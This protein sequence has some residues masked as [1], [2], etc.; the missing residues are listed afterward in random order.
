MNLIKFK[1]AIK[2][3]DDMFNTYC[4]GKYCYWVRCQYAIPL[5]FITPE[6]YVEVEMNI[7]KLQDLKAADGSN[8]YW[9]LLKSNSNIVSYI[10]EKAT[11]DVN[12]VKNY[13]ISNRFTTDYMVTE[14]EVRKFRTWL[15]STLLE[16]DQNNKNEQLCELYTEEFTHVLQYY[17]NGLE[18]DM[19][20]WLNVFGVTEAKIVNTKNIAPPINTVDI[21]KRNIYNTMVSKFSTMDFWSGYSDLFLTEF[22]IYIDNIISLNLDLHQSPYSDVLLND[23]VVN[24][25]TQKRCIFILENLS[26]SL[27]FMLEGDL[28]G[29]VNFINQS[30]QEWATTLFETMEWEDKKTCNYCEI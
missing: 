2:P 14:D 7:D 1:D 19:T 22:K 29:H 24:D 18:D 17:A 30:F 16:F 9:D 4:K 8:L 28:E 21:Y 12:C 11:D 10:D 20:K 5:E 3:N 6:Q 26:K 13:I 15:V 23:M 25:K 27:G